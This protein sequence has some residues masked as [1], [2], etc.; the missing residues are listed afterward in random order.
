MNREKLTELGRAFGCPE[1]R[2][3]PPGVYFRCDQAKLDAERDAAAVE[4]QAAIERY[5][6]RF[7]HVA[8]ERSRRRRGRLASADGLK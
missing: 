3:D 2:L 4:I 6:W 8:R 5:Q 7:S 1:R